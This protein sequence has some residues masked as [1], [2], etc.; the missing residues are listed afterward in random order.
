MASSL[1][2]TAQVYRGRNGQS[3]FRL[4]ATRGRTKTYVVISE[5]ELELDEW[6]KVNGFER[7]VLP[8]AISLSE[9]RH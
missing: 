1:M 6:L 3:F 7:V 9:T 8:D 4:S 2:T 5:S